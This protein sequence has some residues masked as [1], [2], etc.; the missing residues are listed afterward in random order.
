MEKESK[1]TEEKEEKKTEEKESSE[2][3]KKTEEE[4]VEKKVEEKEV[5]I[6]KTNAFVNAKGLP[7]STKHSI[8]VCK[9]IKGKKIEKAIVDLEKVSL[10]KKAIPMKGEIPHRKGM[11]SG[12]YPK[13]TSE[14]FIRLLKNLS[15]N[16]NV[17][18]LES[19]VISEAIANLASRPYSKFGRVRKKRTHIKIVATQESINSENQGKSN[20][21]KEKIINEVK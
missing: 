10:L 8:A 18:G 15:A 20:Q 17:N 7:I 3:T 2:E 4:S 13:K 11:M 6:K 5:K 1:K 12:R 19:P 16:S 14:Y 9:F 21:V